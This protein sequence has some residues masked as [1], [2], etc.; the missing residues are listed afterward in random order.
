MTYKEKFQCLLSEI[1]LL[2]KGDDGINRWFS[3]NL[4]RQDLIW[5]LH[6]ILGTLD[7]REEINKKNRQYPNQEEQQFCREILTALGFICIHFKKD[8]F[9][10]FFEFMSGL[11]DHPNFKEFE[12]EIDTE[13][14]DA[15]IGKIFTK[16]AW[17]LLWK[18]IEFK[19]P[20]LEN[21]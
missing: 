14:V 18:W 15:K 19:K 7:K 3:S 4:E 11:S 6:G 2:R 13:E 1:A 12:Q 5:R 17:L 9:E 21:F 8:S 16:I 20:A 10:G